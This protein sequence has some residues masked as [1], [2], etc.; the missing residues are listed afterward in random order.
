MNPYDS[1]TGKDGNLEILNCFLKIL[2]FFENLT[3]FEIF[4]FV[5]RFPAFPNSLCYY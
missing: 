3:L 2:Y 1:M 4:E 5:I